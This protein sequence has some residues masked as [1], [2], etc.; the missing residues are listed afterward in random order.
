MTF[1]WLC[2]ASTLGWFISTLAGGGSSLILIPL[3]GLMLGAAAIPPVI[4]I[5]CIFGN[6]ERSFAY[7]QRIN[8]QVIRWELP[9]A[10][11]GSILGVF[12]LTQLKLEWLTILVA[13]FLIVSGINS[14]FKPETQSFSVRAW[15]FLPAGFIYAFLSGIM[16]G[17]GPLLAP[18]YLNYGLKKEELL[19][20]QAMTRTV[21][22]LVKIVAYAIFGI[23]TLPYMG[24][25]VLIGIAA[26]P[27]NWLG[28]LTLEKI[29]EQRFQQFLISFIILSGIL[30]L[31]QQRYTLP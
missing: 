20:T 17:T 9:G 8:W 6:A 19:A 31:W 3:V 22:H 12:T 15:Y 29:S 11:A 7:R 13:L 24:Y 25:G 26:F 30:L 16:G 27:G 23:L 5:G 2:L 10:L 1:F 18:F 14:I 28:H 21:I 4:T